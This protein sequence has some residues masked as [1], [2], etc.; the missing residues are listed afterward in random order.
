MKNEEY[1]RKVF[2]I[3]HSSFIISFNNNFKISA[4]AE[5]ED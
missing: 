1:K 5:N 3:L 2:F 4:N